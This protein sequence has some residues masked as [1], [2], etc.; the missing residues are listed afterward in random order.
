VT[1]A[2][3]KL[4]SPL[5]LAPVLRRTISDGVLETIREAIIT[6]TFVAGTHLGEVALSQQ[7]E[8]SRAPIRE[9]MMQLEREGL[10]VFDRR[11]AALVREFTPADLEEIQS[12]RLALECMAARLACRHLDEDFGARFEENLQQT[13]EAERPTD[14]GFL[15]V[16]F[17]DLIV[18]CSRHSRLYGAWANL[19]HQLEVWLVR[20]Y[21]R[22]DSPL[23]KARKLMVRHHQKILQILRTG[24]EERTEKVLHEHIQRWRR[25]HLRPER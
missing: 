15:D 6:G 14:L 21:A 5:P 16:R 20:M 9:A 10:L 18:Q 7:L 11:G 3:A 8:V 4:S 22:W 12:L 19:R 13:R 23:T 24:D 17:H 2:S 25:R 1:D